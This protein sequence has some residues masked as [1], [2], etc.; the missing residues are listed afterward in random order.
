MFNSPGKQ[1]IHKNDDKIHRI[2]FALWP[3]DAT[4][5]QIVVSFKQLSIDKKRGRIVSFD[6]LHIT[7]HFVGNV[8]QQKLDC[9][10]RAAQ[11]VK[12]GSFNLELDHYGYFNKP[13]VLWMGLKQT[14][15]ALETLHKTLGES[16]AECDFQ[17]ERRPYAPHMTLMRKPTQL[18]AFEKIKP[19]YWQVKSFVLVE[20]I[21]IEGGV[22]Y[23]VR[24]QYMLK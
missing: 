23:E 4:R 6:N 15:E 21:S 17:V 9:L 12:A 8:N 14:P 18:E 5:K 2:F 24:E 7:L 1:N 13:K 20:S 19:I 11:T 3:D 10:H 16:L 22:R